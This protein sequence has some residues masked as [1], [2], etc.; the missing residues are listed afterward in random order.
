MPPNRSAPVA[1]WRLPALATRLSRTGSGPP[2]SRC[3]RAPISSSRPC[4]CCTI[5]APRSRRLALL[6]VGPAQGVISTDELLHWLHDPDPEVRRLCEFALSSRKVPREHIHLGRTLT[7][8]DYHVRLN[9][10]DELHGAREIDA[11]IWLRYLSHDP[12][13]SVR[14]AAIRA[15]VEQRFGTQV[16]LRDRLEQMSRS[17]PSLTVRQEAGH[18]LS[19]VRD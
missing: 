8:P 11:G 1:P 3:T 12:K 19:Q 18:Y 13:E 7:D 17:D 16:D 2:S 6:I 10:L 4:H 5:P 15:A 14:V 9:I